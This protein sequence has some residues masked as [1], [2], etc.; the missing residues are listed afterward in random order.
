MQELWYM[1]IF[2]GVFPATACFACIFDYAS[3][4]HQWNWENYRKTLN[5]CLKLGP[6]AK[7]SSVILMKEQGE[8]KSKHAKVDVLYFV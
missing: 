1:E 4:L 3:T 5:I 7:E 2:N 8:T 6:G